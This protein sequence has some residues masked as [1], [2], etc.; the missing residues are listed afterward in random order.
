MTIQLPDLFENMKE[1]AEYIELELTPMTGLYMLVFFGFMDT[2]VCGAVH[3]RYLKALAKE[4]GEAVRAGT[5][6]V[7]DVEGAMPIAEARPAKA[8]PAGSRF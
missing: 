2:F 8:S 5:F 3:E 1:A 4:S 6:A 7:V